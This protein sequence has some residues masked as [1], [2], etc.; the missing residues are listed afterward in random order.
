MIDKSKLGFNAFWFGGLERTDEVKK[1]VDALYNMG[2]RG[3]EWKETSFINGANLGRD[4]YNA[5]KISREGGLEVTDAVIL[6]N[7][8]DPEVSKKNTAQIVNFI[9]C[10]A[11]AGIRKVNLPSGGRRKTYLADQDKIACSPT[12]DI[13]WATLKASLEELVKAAE[14]E[15]V[16]LVLEPIVG[17]VVR[18]YHTVLELFET[19]DSPTLCLTMDP[20][21]FQ[22]VGN[23][24]PRA[25]RHFGSGKIRHVHMKDA[26]GRPGVC[27][28][29]F[30]FPLLGEGAVDWN[31][32][33]EALDGIGYDGFLSVEFESWKY[34]DEVLQ[35][36]FEA[37]RLSM[38]SA[39]VLLDR[40]LHDK[41]ENSNGGSNQ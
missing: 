39:E 22:L 15:K 21:H 7:L 29:D 25:I 4:L 26:I 19:I 38:R 3:V 9:R 1:V 12:E 27:G 18:D 20:S 32:F 10:C 37:A 8:C 24:I 36:A 23:D 28:E 14:E 35:S 41:K 40:Y 31:G 17:Q 5:A 6:R 33:L 34:M 11:G 16:Y 13:A 30:L 2:Y